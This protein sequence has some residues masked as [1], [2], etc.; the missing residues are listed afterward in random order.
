MILSKESVPSRAQTIALAQEVIDKYKGQKLKTL[1]KELIL[2]RGIIAMYG[3]ML[4]EE[5]YGKY[6]SE[7]FPEFRPMD[8]S[9]MDD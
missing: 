1:P 2:A 5:Q 4:F 6:G 3:Q 7:I 8:W 9:G